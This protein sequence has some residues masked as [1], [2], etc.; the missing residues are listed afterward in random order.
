MGR[1]EVPREIPPLGIFDRCPA[2]LEVYQSLVYF[3]RRQDR[4]SGPVR[5]AGRAAEVR[6][7]PRPGG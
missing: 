7:R 6:R 1:T 5:Q 3:D 4:S 2:H